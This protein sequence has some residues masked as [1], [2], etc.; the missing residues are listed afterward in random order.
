LRHLEAAGFDGAPRVFGIDERGREI[1]EFIEGEVA[2]PEPHLRALATN[3]TVR[4]VGE[5][6]RAFHE[7]VA[8]FVPPPDAVWRYPEMADDAMPFVDARGVII[9]HNDPAAWNI[10]VN[11][12]RVAFIDWDVAGPRPPIWDVAYCAVGVVPIAPAAAVDV[13]P[14]LRALADGYDLSGSDRRRLPHVIV[15]RIASS[16][17]HL[18]RRAE[19]GV[20]PWDEMW[21]NGHGD[22]WASMLEFASTHAD[23]WSA[24]T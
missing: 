13:V 16:Y 21:R 1:L 10:V 5:L 14:R 8:T 7:A 24:A 11:P 22:A 12:Q 9:C 17:A 23:E 6:L 2:W 4:R 18:R 3:D 15:A 19:A 20:A